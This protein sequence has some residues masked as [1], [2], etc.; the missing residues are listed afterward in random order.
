MLLHPFPTVQLSW[1]SSLPY[2]QKLVRAGMAQS[3]SSHSTVVVAVPS[4]SVRSCLPSEIRLR[5]AHLHF[6]NSLHVSELSLD[7]LHLEYQGN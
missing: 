5:S 7:E 3:S 6:R 2:M 4:G 1:V